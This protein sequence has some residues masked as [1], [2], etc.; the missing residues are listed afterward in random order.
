MTTVAARYQS[1]SSAC[2]HGGSS[3]TRSAMPSACASSVSWSGSARPVPLGPPTNATVRVR[4]RAG[5]SR[6]RLA[7]ARSTTSGALSGWTRPA[8]TMT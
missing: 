2:G 1:A 7:A 8:N 5:S 4:A 3:R 6:T